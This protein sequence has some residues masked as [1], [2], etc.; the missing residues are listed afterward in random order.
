MSLSDDMLKGTTASTAFG[1]ATS[2]VM[3]TVSPLIQDAGC[4][5]WFDASDPDGTGTQPANGSNISIWKNKSGSNNVA[6]AVSGPLTYNSTGLNGLPSLRFNGSQYLK[7][8]VTNTNP[9]MTIFCVCSIDQGCDSHARV[10]A[11]VQNTSLNDYGHN[12]A[13][14]I[15][16]EGGTGLQGLRGYHAGSTSIEATYGNPYLFE[17]WFD[18]AIMYS[19]VSAGSES[20][21]ASS[22]NFNI[23]EFVIGNQGQIQPTP[24]STV[25]IFTGYISEIL[26]YNTSLTIPQRQHV[27]G[28]LSW[29]WSLNMNLPPQHPFWGSAS[30]SALEQNLLETINPVLRDVSGITLKANLIDQANILT[31]QENVTFTLN[32]ELNRLNTKAPIVD[33]LLLQQ[34]RVSDL[35]TSYTKKSNM[36]ISIVRY[37]VAV[38]ALLVI[39]GI[40][41]SYNDGWIP[42]PVITFIMVCIIAPS[43]IYIGILISR[44]NNRD[45]LDFDKL[46]QLNMM[47][48][49]IA[50]A[51]GVLVAP[52][53]TS[54]LMAEFAGSCVGAHCC[55][56]NTTFD[57]A[58]GGCVKVTKQPFTGMNAGNDGNDGNNGVKPYSSN[59]NS[60]YKWLSPFP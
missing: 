28:Y 23:G 13:C 29:K 19:T 48:P 41:G 17:T 51:S 57:T 14:C 53:L 50:N 20:T 30:A 49:L 36:Y 56:D 32:S 10:L 26:V 24:T 40:A 15:T 11:L 39:I 3:S 25:G 52:S 43:I 34:E 58:S 7:G 22:G 27:E 21:T 9:T 16:H 42:A 60:M 6:T 2:N 5:L 31:Q 44:Y 18:G 35:Q 33:Q 59:N 38:L 54:G 37:I 45:S 46:N 8:A 1:T 12:E 4:I 55:G 47:S